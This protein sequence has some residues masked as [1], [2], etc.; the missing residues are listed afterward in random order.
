MLLL[1]LLADE[2]V[3][4]FAFILDTFGSFD[5]FVDIFEHNLVLHHFLSCLKDF[6]IAIAQIRVEREVTS[7]LGHVLHGVEVVVEGAGKRGR[8]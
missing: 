7:L 5:V 4:L 3:M 6:R 8:R 2:V 1:L